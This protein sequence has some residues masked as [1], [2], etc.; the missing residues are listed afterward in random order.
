[1]A[2]VIN[3]TVSRG[4]SVLIPA[5]A[6]DRT[7]IVLHLIKQLRDA[8]EI[9]DVPVFV[10]SPMALEALRVY[11]AAF[12]GHASDTR[13]D[14]GSDPFGLEY[15]RLAASV[16]DSM[17]LNHPCRP[18]IIVSAS[19]MASGGRV[20][21]HLAHMVGER[22]NTVVWVGYQAL[23]TRGY[24]L[25]H[26]ASS[27]KVLGRYVPVRARVESFDGMSV[28]ADE[29]E[30]ISWLSDGTSVP[31]VVYVVHGDEPA[32]SLLADRIKR[33]LGWLT[34]LPRQAEIVRVD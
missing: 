25:V 29:D 23:G 15:V 30:L 9:P 26:G 31:D 13:P 33:D 16:E 20:V 34:V 19:G 11:Q 14:L 4:G 2:R 18:C 12:A 10:D 27:I 8:G 3:E 1:L 22:R 21:H 32:R 24:D 28:H 7:E 5:F 6:V 17:R